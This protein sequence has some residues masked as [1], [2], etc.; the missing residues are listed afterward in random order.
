[1]LLINVEKEMESLQKCADCYVNN[2][3]DAFLVCSKPHLLLWAQYDIYP[4]WPVKILSINEASKTLEVF[5]FN[6][7][8]SADVS[9]ENCFLYM[10]EDPNNYITDQYKD[11]IKKAMEVRSIYLLNYYKNDTEFEIF[12]HIGS[13]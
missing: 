5:F 6:D 12:C 9:Y 11:D 3:I 13:Q 1:M 10:N 7:H 2:N 4:Y 8:T